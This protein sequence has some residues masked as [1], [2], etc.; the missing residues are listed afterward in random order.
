MK[1]LLF[2]TI[3]F[4]LIFPQP[5]TI[6][7]RP[8]PEW[9]KPGFYVEYFVDSTSIGLWILPNSSL[10]NS[11]PNL[12]GLG[13]ITREGLYPCNGTYRFELIDMNATFARF[14]VS[15]DLNAWRPHKRL[16]MPGEKIIWIP[17]K[18]LQTSFTCDV[19]L[20]TLATYKDG[21]F[22]GIFP[23][24]RSFT[25]QRNR[26]ILL[27][28]LFGKRVDA[29]YI[30]L[31]KLVSFETPL[32]TFRYVFVVDAEI[33]LSLPYVNSPCIFTTNSVYERDSSLLVFGG[34]YMDDILLENG[35]LCFDWIEIKETTV[36]FPQLKEERS[37]FVQ[38]GHFFLAL[39][40]A[41]VALP[42]LYKLLIRFRIVKRLV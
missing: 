13:E 15:L 29:N 17:F 37:S 5:I 22:I 23:L 27:L 6:R 1:N 32:G 38:G 19:E 9:L 31:E 26:T 3:L 10:Y 39:L 41:G 2:L 34:M 40:F 7:L 33:V 4:F 28:N 18:M 30:F 42:F 36:E 8:E 20:E 16:I 14:N 35:I 25:S 24:W 21:K 12:T 11:L